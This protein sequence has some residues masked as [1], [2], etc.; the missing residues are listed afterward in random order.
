MLPID[1]PIKNSKGRHLKA[2]NSN[3]QPFLSSLGELSR[4]S[5]V[6][7]EKFGE[8]ILSAKDGSVVGTIAKLPEAT[9]HLV[10]LPHFS[11]LDY[12]TENKQ[13]WSE[14][15]AQL[16]KAVVGQMFAIDKF[17]KKYSSETLAPDW[18]GKKKSPRAVQEIDGN[19]AR[20]EDEISA[21]EARRNEERDRKK[22]LQAVSRLLYENG[23]ALEAAIEDGLRVLG[24]KVENFRVG[25]L[26]ID[27]III[28]PSGKRMIGES[29]G[30]DTS[31]IDISK[32][33]QLESNINE[34]FQREEVEVPAKGILFG[35]GYRLRDPAERPDEFTAKC[36]TNAKRLGT[37]LVRTSDLYEAVVR[38][39]DNPEDE[40]FRV[41][42]RQA[43]EETDG[44]VVVFPPAT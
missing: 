31:A 42:C 14:K 1:L 26:E 2:V 9:G 16:S 27:H 3:F 12:D 21:L 5:V 22:N 7:R 39:L 34:D 35:N 23:K 30:K 38:A 33:R 8:P 10:L 19:I 4:Y 29:E 20:I 43:I 25:D 28:G 40:S 11:F 18:L 6:F 37:A 15:A 36:M 24:F 44:A 32:F 41:C 13:D 17:L